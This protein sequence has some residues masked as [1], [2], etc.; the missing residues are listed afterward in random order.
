[1][2]NPSLRF[3]PVALGPILIPKLACK[4]WATCSLTLL[5]VSVRSLSSAAQ[6]GLLSELATLQGMLCMDFI[7]FGTE[8]SARG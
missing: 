6:G 3:V 8:I 4:T 7:V 5:W 2:C 1:M